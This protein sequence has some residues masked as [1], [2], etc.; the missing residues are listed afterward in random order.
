MKNALL[1]IALGLGG[2]ALLLCAF[3]LPYA[4]AWLLIPTGVY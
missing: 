2:T 3:V 1:S 4:L